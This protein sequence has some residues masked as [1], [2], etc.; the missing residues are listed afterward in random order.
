MVGTIAAMTVATNLTLQP[1]E[2]SPANGGGLLA[3]A[4]DD[5][6]GADVREL[7]EVT[8]REESLARA[9][10]I[11]LS[12]PSGRKRPVPPAPEPDLPEPSGDAAA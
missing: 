6:D 2:L 8:E 3:G 7:A 4:T 1:V 11:A 10:I 5:A 12:N 9:G